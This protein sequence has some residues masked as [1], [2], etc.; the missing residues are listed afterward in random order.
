MT[1]A[2]EIRRRFN[3]AKGKSCYNHLD[4]HEKLRDTIKR[5]TMHAEKK[6]KIKKKLNRGV[7]VEYKKSDARIKLEKK[8]TNMFR[9]ANL[10]IEG[11]NWD[12]EDENLERETNKK[13]LAHI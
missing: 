8:I 6:S 7:N 12:D 1:M 2:D 11:I 13:L 3:R 5:N 9:R 4:I 10:K